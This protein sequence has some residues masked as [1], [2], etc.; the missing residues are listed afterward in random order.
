MININYVAVVSAA[1]LEG[2]EIV[3]R[4]L[5]RNDVELVWKEIPQDKRRGFITK[6]TIFYKN[7]SKTHCMYPSC[8]ILNTLFSPYIYSFLLSVGLNWYFFSDSIPTVS[9]TCWFLF[10][11]FAAVTVPANTT[12]YTLTS[13]SGNTRYDA[14]ISASTIGGSA[15]S[16]NHSFWTLKYGECKRSPRIE[17]SWLFKKCPKTIWQF[18]LF[19]EIVN[20]FIV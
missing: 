13:L 2:P 9:F 6:Y 20:W 10:C 12:S 7:G 15:R 8:Y 16:L 19:I 14:W 3:D 4:K 18:I 17:M 5:G 11:W 1:P